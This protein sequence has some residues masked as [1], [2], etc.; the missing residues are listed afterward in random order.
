MAIVH[1]EH[2]HHFPRVNLFW[3]TLL[4]SVAIFLG[5]FLPASALL[6]F[7]YG[8]AWAAVAMMAGFFAVWGLSIAVFRMELRWRY[9]SGSKITR[10]SRICP[11]DGG[12]CRE[13]ECNAS[14]VGG[15]AEQQQA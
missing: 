15:T 7:G 10:R 2:L 12:C 3:G 8:S 5:A 6:Y 1:N 14:N 4:M 13:T 11:Q 9:G